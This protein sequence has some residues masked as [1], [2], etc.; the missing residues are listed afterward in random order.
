MKGKFMNTCPVTGGLCLNPLC[1]FGC[2]E[3]KYEQLTLSSCL[4]RLRQIALLNG[5]KL[6]NPKHLKLMRKIMEV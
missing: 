6:S 1:A 3:S 5:L 4:P 2:I